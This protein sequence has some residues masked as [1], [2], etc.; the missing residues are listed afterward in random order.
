MNCFKFIKKLL[1]CGWCQDE[2]ENGLA[3]LVAE[4]HYLD[5]DEISHFSYSTSSS[6]SDNEDF[7]YI[8]DRIVL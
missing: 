5:K 8:I 3:K 1:V 2:E 6:S 7:D 4:S